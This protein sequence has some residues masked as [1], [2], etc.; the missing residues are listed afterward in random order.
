VWA[1]R[2]RITALRKSRRFLRT[3]R[4]LGLPAGQHAAR[5]VAREDPALEEK[6]RVEQTWGGGGFFSPLFVFVDP[7]QIMRGNPALK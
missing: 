4:L 3:F 2:W 1:A 5:V 6:N 7:P